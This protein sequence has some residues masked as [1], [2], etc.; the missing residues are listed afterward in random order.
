MYFV[1][2]YSQRLCFTCLLIHIKYIWGKNYIILMVAFFD[3]TNSLTV[4]LM[5]FFSFTV[6]VCVCC[7]LRNECCHVHG[8]WA[9]IGIYPMTEEMVCSHLPQVLSICVIGFKQIFNH[10]S[11]KFLENHWQSVSFQQNRR[12]WCWER[13]LRFAL[14]VIFYNIFPLKLA[15]YLTST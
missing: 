4:Y 7:P 11:E 14:C 12:Y 5:W 13:L 15:N 2:A 3:S 8:L 1:A 6:C 10:T 9:Q